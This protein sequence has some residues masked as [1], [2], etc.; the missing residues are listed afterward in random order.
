VRPASEARRAAVRD[1]CRRGLICPSGKFL[2]I[3][4]SPR[5]K[6]KSLR[7]QLKSVASSVPSRLAP[8]G[9]FAIVTNVELRD[10]VDALFLRT[11]NA[12]EGG[13][14]SRVVLMSRR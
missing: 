9:R 13:R 7:A 8:E 14:R 6:N 2:E 4:S 3:L 12:G 5:E 11:T 10:A 1:V